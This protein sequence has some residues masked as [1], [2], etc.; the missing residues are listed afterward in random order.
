[1][2]GCR[3]MVQYRQS[4]ALVWSEK[5]LSP[6]IFKRKQNLLVIGNRVPARLNSAEN[7]EEKSQARYPSRRNA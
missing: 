1:V 2:S 7:A 4:R 6:S 5:R 3:F